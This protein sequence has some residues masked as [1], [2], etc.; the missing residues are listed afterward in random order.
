MIRMAP[1]NGIKIHDKHP[2]NRIG[3][4]QVKSNNSCFHFSISV[5]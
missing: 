2:E 4:G 5:I 3:S 1:K